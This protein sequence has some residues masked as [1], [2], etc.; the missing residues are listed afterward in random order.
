VGAPKKGR[1]FGAAKR[2]VRALCFF[3][4]TTQKTAPFIAKV[5]KD[6][7][8]VLR[9]LVES[10]KLVPVIDRSYPLS[11]TAEAL[12]YLEQGRARGKI[13]ITV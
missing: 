11:Q 10:G 9:E 7:L 4:F 2:L 5:T 13:I 8:L 3:A 1:V 6:E 12:P